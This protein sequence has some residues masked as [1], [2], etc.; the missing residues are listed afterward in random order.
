MGKLA[1]VGSISRGGTGYKASAVQIPNMGGV[2]II[3]DDYASR[4]MLRLMLEREMHTVWEADSPENGWRVLEKDAVPDLLISD[5][6]LG[7]STGIDLLR[8][9]RDDPIW[10]GLPVILVSASPKREAVA[11]SLSLQPVAFLTKPYD[12]HRIHA[13]VAKALAVRW[14]RQ[15]F[16]DPLLVLQRLRI[17]REKALELARSLFAELAGLAALA[18]QAEDNPG[19]TFTDIMRS[20]SELGLSSLENELRRCTRPDRAAHEG[21]PL[22]TRL[23]VLERLYAANIAH[24][25]MALY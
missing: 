1:C 10:N 18:A 22:L 5:L 21:A 7:E 24:Q 19:R 2:L 8:Q 11:E 3:E 25:R 13:A 23:P 16:E 4:R 12:Y 9:V 14:C 15:H 20:V 6:W 17:D